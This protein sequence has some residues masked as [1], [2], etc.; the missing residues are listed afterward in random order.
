LILLDLRLPD[1]DGYDVCRILKNQ[2]ETTAIPIIIVSTRSK[3]TE[4]VVGLEVG[5]DDYLTKPYNDLELLARIRVAL[6]RRP[7]SFSTTGKNETEKT[8]NKFIELDA[9]G[10]NVVVEGVPIVLTRKEFDLL[11][12]LM[13]REGKAV[14]RATILEAVWGNSFD[15]LQGT[16]DTHVKTL[17]KKLGNAGSLIETLPGIGYRWKCK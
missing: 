11:A 9:E 3:D 4:K 6:R 5:A 13:S 12:Y 7:V 2:P 14:T 1:M 15:S 17:R 16:V 10:R 8:R